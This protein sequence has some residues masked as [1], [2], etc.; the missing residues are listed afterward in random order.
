MAFYKMQLHNFDNKILKN[1]Y[2]QG[3][4]TLKKFANLFVIFLKIEILSLSGYF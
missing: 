1:A 4:C 2:F 3:F